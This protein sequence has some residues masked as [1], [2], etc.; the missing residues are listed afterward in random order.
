MYQGLNSVITTFLRQFGVPNC[1]Y[2]GNFR[3]ILQK[4]KYDLIIFLDDRVL[5][6]EPG[7]DYLTWVLVTVN[8]LQFI[9]F[10]LI[11]R[12][13]LVPVLVLIS[14]LIRRIFS[15]LNQC[16]IIWVLPSIALGRRFPSRVLERRKSEIKFKYFT[17]I[18]T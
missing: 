5:V 10:K 6:L 2:I 18:L 3:E 9:I 14:A 11:I 8:F 7:E 4:R 12:P 17:F 15:N 13:L 16:L 1:L